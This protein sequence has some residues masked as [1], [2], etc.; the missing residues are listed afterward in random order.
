M[1]KCEQWGGLAQFW[2]FYLNVTIEC[3][4]CMKR[5]YDLYCPSTTT[6]SAEYVCANARWKKI[7]TTKKL[8]KFSLRA[9]QHCSYETDESSLKT[10]SLKI[11]K[12]KC[13]WKVLKCLC[14]VLLFFVMISRLSHCFNF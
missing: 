3:P 7:Y 9:T 13:S 2:S 11:K 10:A 6:N 4:K 12:W 1:D 14:C 5:P 8:L